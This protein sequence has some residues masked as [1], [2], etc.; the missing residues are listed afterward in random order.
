M[1]T[2]KVYIAT[3]GDAIKIG[4]S[5]DPKTRVKDL[6]VGNPKEITLLHEIAVDGVDYTASE[7]EKTLHNA[8]DEWS[9]NGEW[10]DIEAYHYVAGLVKGV[11]VELGKVDI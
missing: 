3:T 5:V 6:S 10:F 1:T 9:Q 8:C 7:F 2:Q 4:K 11:G